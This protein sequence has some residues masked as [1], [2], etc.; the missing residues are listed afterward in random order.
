MRNLLLFIWKNQ[1]TFLFFLLEIVGFALLA[2]NNNYQRSKL[3]STTVAISGTVYDM[4]DS[5][6]KYIGL[7]DENS[8]L[9]EENAQLRED[10]FWKDLSMSPASA[11]P[12]SKNYEIIPAR[13]INST[14]SEGNNFMIIDKGSLDGIKT[15]MGVI[16]PQGVVGVITHVS[17]NF[18]A[19]MPV[20]HSQSQVSCRLKQ[21]DYFGICRWDGLDDRFIDLEDIPNQVAVEKGDTV[22]TR[23]SNGIFPNGIIVGF[24]ENSEKDE[25]SGFQRIRVRLATNFRNVNSVYAI[26]NQRKSELDSLYR[27]VKPWMDK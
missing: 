1:F 10:L 26:G 15:E 4:Q 2:T 14:Y 12:L 21:S 7:L 5:Y 23:G 22:I 8:K 16:G 18:S 24:A 9:Q 13:A 6:L 11:T 17:G 20:I 27:E 19:I 25:S 3:H